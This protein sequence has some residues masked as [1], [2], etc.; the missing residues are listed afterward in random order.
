MTIK[1][2]LTRRMVTAYLPVLGRVAESITGFF[3]DER[4][5]RVATSVD[6]KPFVADG[7]RVQPINEVGDTMQRPAAA[8]A[9]TPPAPVTGGRGTYTNAFGREINEAEGT[10]RTAFG[11]LIAESKST[12][13][14]GRTIKEN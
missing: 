13:A 3:T 5:N 9:A 7:V 10:P 6:S 11:R 2:T 4:G 14:F 8:G 12:N 1:S